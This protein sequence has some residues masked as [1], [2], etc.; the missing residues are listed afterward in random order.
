M[1]SASAYG[2]GVH[3]HTPEIEQNLAQLTERR[4]ARQLHAGAGADAARHPRDRD[5]AARVRG[6]R[7]GRARRLHRAYEKEPFVHL[8]PA[9]QWPQTKATLGSNAVHLQVTA[10][11]ARRP[12]G[13]GRRDRQ[14]HQGHGRRRRPVHEPRARP[15]RDDRSE[16][17]GWRHDGRGR[18][19]G[20]SDDADDA[21]N[22]DDWRLRALTDPSR[23]CAAILATPCR[24]GSGRPATWSRSPA[25]PTSCRS[26][27]RPRRW[28][29]GR[30]RGRALHR[31][32][33]STQQLDFG[34]T[35]VLSSLLEPLA[36]AEIS[37]LAL[38]DLRHR[39]DPGARRPGRRGGCR[40]AT[41]RATPFLTPHLATT[42][43]D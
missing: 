32:S 15:R 4:G 39:L 11:A 6:R 21:A 20:H 28:C 26:S 37:I 13:R 1:G 33:W 25:P 14:P 27:A 19:G 36:E 5:G 18:H 17:S 2:V 12:A 31:L 22:A 8:L 38:L 3:R 16:P 10:D 41:T 35:G 30:R 43:K 29:R 24:P 42:P 23:C 34:L 9:G 7:R 40:L